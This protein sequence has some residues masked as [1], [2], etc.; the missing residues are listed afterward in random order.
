MLPIGAS[1]AVSQESV[2]P[3]RIVVG[4]RFALDDRDRPLLTSMAVTDAPARTTK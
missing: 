1:V 4:P 2:F 3:E